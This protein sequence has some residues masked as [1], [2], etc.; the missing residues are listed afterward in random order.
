MKPLSI[1]L[2]EKLIQRVDGVRQET[3]QRAEPG[4][5]ITRSSAIRVLLQEALERRGRWCAT[6]SSRS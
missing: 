4:L 5:T 2:P 3:Q 6:S 1:K